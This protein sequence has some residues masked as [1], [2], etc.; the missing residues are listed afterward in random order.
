MF[1][2]GIQ[3]FATQ[4][5]PAVFKS[6]D[7]DSLVMAA[8]A[9]E[10]HSCQLGDDELTSAFADGRRIGDQNGE[11]IDAIFVRAAGLGAAAVQRTMGFRLHD[12]QIKGALATARGSIIE[13]QTGEGKT[14]VSGL[15]A[16][17]RAAIDRTVH[18]ATTTD[19]LAERDHES[20]AAIFNALGLRSAVLSHDAEPDETKSH[21][22]C[23]IVYG[24]G[25]LFGF[26]YLRDQLRLRQAGE[27]TLGRDVLEMINGTDFSEQ[28]VQTQH[29]CI[30]VDEADSV[31]IDEAATPLILSGSETFSESTEA[32]THAKAIANDLVDP[33]EYTI[34]L[35]M[36]QI[37]LT[38]AGA[39][40]AYKS[41]RKIGRLELSRP[42]TTYVE[43][44]LY[45]EHLL[46]RDEHYV[47]RDE[48]ISLVDQLTGRIFDDRTL[49]G[50]LHQAVECKEDLE[51][52]PPNRSMA[53]VTRQR[54]F[55]MYD[56]VCGM[57]GTASGSEEELE[58][59]YEAKIV[60]LQPNV[61]SKR[62][63]L[64]TRFFADWGAKCIAIVDEVKRLRETGRPIL[65]GTRTIRESDL[66]DQVLQQ[67][68]IHCT[69]LNGVQDADEADIIKEAGKVGSL[70]IATNMAG[71][72]TD[73]KL[74]AESRELGGL[75]V[76]ATQR[77]SSARVDRQLAGRAARQ[78]DPGSCQ[79]FVAADDEL[80]T[81]HGHKLRDQIRAASKH[82]RVAGESK[83]DFSP[84]N[85][86][87]SASDRK[88]RI[89][90]TTQIGPSRQLDGQNPRINGRQRMNTFKLRQ[91]VLQPHSR[92][93]HTSRSRCSMIATTCVCLLML[94]A[95]TVS[96]QVT[97]SF[98]EPINQSDVA[99][100]ESG[101]IA[102]IDIVEGQ[103]VKAGDVLARLDHEALT[104]T[105][106]I[107]ELR[108]TSKSELLKAEATL[109]ARKKRRDT[110]EPMLKAGHA[111]E[112]EFE[113]AVVEYEIAASDLELAK[114]KSAEY[115]LDV[116]RIK[117]EIKACTIQSPINGV[118]SE[119]HYRLGEYVSGNKP[120]FAT[121][122]QLD[123]LV[124]RFYLLETDVLQLSIGQQV[125]LSLRTGE[126][127]TQVAG[128]IKFVSPVTDPDSSTARVDVVI[129]NTA[130]HYRSGSPCHWLGTSKSANQNGS[131]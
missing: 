124:V 10:D 79:F 112:T 23:D 50:G 116:G 37:A 3:R 63:E 101:V 83:R 99:A 36:R 88:I 26:D 44:A 108:A 113:E 48:G 131:L 93:M 22:Q 24:P 107:S 20:V 111:N 86:A 100:S 62:I 49:R 76:L 72:G 102:S 98:T 66:V 51:V 43:N 8:R 129:D 1:T 19:Y 15:A 114:E 78:G 13:M 52:K 29:H 28:L 59:F 75:H 120:Q 91:D 122:V 21:Y 38:D 123:R 9:A 106:R 77:N 70:M 84:A 25:Y 90:V 126:T 61:P 115:K 68:A 128:T 119:L 58:F 54:F 117:A 125:P 17:I 60:P 33:D 6:D 80:F 39:E 71:R 81:R 64:P 5:L 56:T 97:Q 73:I 45:A 95:T 69:V 2:A 7:L 103:R 47:V 92:S 12:V 11:H 14:V 85:L 94:S 74:T 32:Y 89:R 35:A 57:T 53:R 16:V 127:F 87:T 121:V 105:L 65:I 96:A 41:L 110:I 18:V 118:V 55:Q 130:G 104:Q 30:I 40:N 34:D 109:R 67:H 27:L 31:L 46:V 82:N 42:W 4:L